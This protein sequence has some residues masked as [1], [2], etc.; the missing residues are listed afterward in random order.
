MS[1]ALKISEKAPLDVLFAAE[2]ARARELFA[3]GSREKILHLSFEE[4]FHVA[5]FNWRLEDLL[6]PEKSPAS[7]VRVKCYYCIFLGLVRLTYA[8]LTPEEFLLAQKIQRKA[9]LSLTEKA[10]ALHLL[11]RLS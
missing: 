5:E 2:S 11:S 3:C 7:M 9:D 4:R 1:D 10:D 6:N 8:R